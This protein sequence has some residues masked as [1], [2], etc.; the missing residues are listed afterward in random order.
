MVKVV[1]MTLCAIVLIAAVGCQTVPCTFAPFASYGKQ[2]EQS[3][4]WQVGMGMSFTLGGNGHVTPVPSTPSL[5]S[6]VSLSSST[7]SSTSSSST[8]SQS[9]TQDQFHHT[10][11]D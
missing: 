9:Q 4:E 3:G 1:Q 6:R 10:N 2:P 11:P 8:Q 5:P 7:S